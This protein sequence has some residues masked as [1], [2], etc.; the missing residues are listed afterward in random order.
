MCVYLWI[1]S[2]PCTAQYISGRC[3]KCRLTNHKLII[4]QPCLY[5][6]F[7]KIQLSDVFL[8][9]TF[10]QF[11]RLKMH[12][13][14]NMTFMHVQTYS[15]ILQG[16]TLNRCEGEFGVLCCCLHTEVKCSGRSRDEQLVEGLSFVFRSHH[17]T[18]AQKS[19]PAYESLS[20]I[21]NIRIT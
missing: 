15:H 16:I 3:R 4:N 5:I 21:A 13:V 12:R 19:H 20:Y 6:V 14:Y 2:A 18:F 11:S 8:R 10:Q 1:Y 9:L 17:H 7:Y